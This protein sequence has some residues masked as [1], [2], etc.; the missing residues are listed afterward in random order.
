MIGERR[1]RGFAE[2][3]DDV[4][5][6]VRNASFRNQF[7]EA[8]RRERRLLGGLEH[9]R[10]ACGER[11]RKL[12][13]RH[14]EREVPRDDLADHADRLAQ[15][16]GVPVAGAGNRNGL[17]LQAR[18]PSSH[19]AEHVDRAADVVA[20]R[21][22]HRLAIVERLEFGE[23]VSVLLEQ[24]AEVPD[25]LR[26]VGGRD[27]RPRS[28][29]ERLPR[30]VHREVDIG[31]V[32]RRDVGDDLLRRRI[33][34]LEGLAALGLDPF[35]VD[36]HVMLLGQ[37]R[38]RVLPSFGLAMAMFIASSLIELVGFEL[39]GSLYPDEYTARGLRPAGGAA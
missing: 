35:A 16:I 12:P 24:V 15:R 13:G 38:L 18:R 9:D 30:R 23:L 10:A 25:E 2:A 36:Q 28:G 8:Q 4:D 19:V 27:A 6:A 5:D 26:A 20:A 22:G 7:A 21:I 1:A 11:R 37:K 29:L 39:M 17:A 14:H 33:F 3:G 32:A 31:L 34:D